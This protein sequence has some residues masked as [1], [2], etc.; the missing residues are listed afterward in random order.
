MAVAPAFYFSSS[1]ICAGF[2]DGDGSTAASANQKQVFS[3]LIQRDQLAEVDGLLPS[4][5]PK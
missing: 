2:D 4:W 1:V 5:N 3:H